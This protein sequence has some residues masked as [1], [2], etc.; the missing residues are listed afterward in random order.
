[1][2]VSCLILRLNRNESIRDSDYGAEE[3]KK[4]LTGAL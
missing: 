2:C 4:I 1:M 3:K